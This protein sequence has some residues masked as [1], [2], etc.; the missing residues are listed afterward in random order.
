MNQIRLGQT[1]VTASSV[2]MGTWAIGG[3]SCWGANNDEESIAAI[4][5]ARECGITLIDTPNG[6]QFK[7]T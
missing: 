1:D 7:R 5:K 6:T 4:Q 3:D 2:G